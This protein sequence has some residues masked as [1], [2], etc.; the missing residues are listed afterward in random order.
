MEAIAVCLFGME[1]TV[2]YELKKMGFEI[3]KVSDGRVTFLCDSNGIAKSNISLRCAERILIKV[4]EFEAKTFEELFENVQKIEV[5]KFLGK[6]DKFNISKVRTINSK[7]ISQRDIQAIVKKSIVERLKKVYNI[8]FIKE[9]NGECNFHI[10]I[11]KN[12]VE[13]TIDTTGAALHKRGYRE[14]STKAPLRETIAAFMIMLSPWK[15][16][17]ILLDPMCGSGTI[18]IEAAMYGA[19]IMPGINRNFAGEK[20]NF[21]P[22]IVWKEERKFAIENENKIDFKIY[23]FDIDEEAINLAK[24]NA[25]LAGVEHL[26]EFKN[27]NIL[28]FKTKK[29]YGFIITN[30]PYGERLGEKEEVENLYKKIGYTI[31][32]MP[33]WSFYIISSKDNTEKLFNIKATKKRKMYNGSLVSNIYIFEGK[34]PQK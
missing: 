16:D 2:S 27:K 18:A 33:T 10:F 11:N 13:I 6:N 19:N 12:I 34:K 23:A 29:E 5:E 25:K 20:L 3:S 30:P 8:D 14:L 28:D 1:S 21:I 4:G 31:K 26:I 9:E 24:E 22:S 7:L 32:N 15:N 17:R